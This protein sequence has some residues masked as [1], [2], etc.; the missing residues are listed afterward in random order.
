MGIDK[1]GDKPLVAT[2]LGRPIMLARL[3]I[4]IT[5]IEDP[6]PNG[7]MPLSAGRITASG[8]E[9]PYHG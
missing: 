9:R 7:N 8:I 1:L 4:G 3:S 2:V 5:V 6:R